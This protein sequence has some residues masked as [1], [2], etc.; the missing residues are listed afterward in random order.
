MLDLVEVG[1][2]PGRTVATVGTLAL[3]AD[4]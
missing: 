4:A 3:A 2:G 1:V